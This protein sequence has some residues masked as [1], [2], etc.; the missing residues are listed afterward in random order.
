MYLIVCVDDK[1]GI[2]FAKKRQ[3]MDTVLRQKILNIC[4]GKR[5]WMREY[6]FKQFDGEAAE[7]VDIKVSETYLADASKGDYC[8][9]EVDDIMPCADKIEGIILCRWNRT[10]PSDKKLLIPGDAK[11]WSVRVLDEFQGK[12]HKKITME[13]W[14][15]T[16]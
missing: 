11:D 1:M 15:K 8:F 2:S 6:T 13:F 9:V 10:Y 14:E 16:K 4:T 5:L 3:S 12:S 7:G